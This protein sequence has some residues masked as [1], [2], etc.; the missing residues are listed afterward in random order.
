[1]KTHHMRA[2]I[3]GLRW[4]VSLRGIRVLTFWVLFNNFVVVIFL[5][6]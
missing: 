2:I 3:F 5:A 6:A 1:M 4:K